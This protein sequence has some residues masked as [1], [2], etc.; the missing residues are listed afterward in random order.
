MTFPNNSNQYLPGVIQIPSTLEITALTNTYPAI[1][2][3]SIEVVTAA[4]TY[5][6]GQLVRLN[7]PYSYGMSQANGLVA[8]V[9]SNN[10]TQLVLDLNTTNFDPFVVPSGNVSQPASVA[11]AGSRNLEYNNS[12]DFVP[13]QSLNNRGN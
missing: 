4:N 9:L 11:P 12:T 1:V 13:F 3:I 7:I 6:F 2:T 10:G 8:T 5:I